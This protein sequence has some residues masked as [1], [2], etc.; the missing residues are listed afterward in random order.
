MAE[1]IFG[2]LACL[3]FVLFFWQWLCGVRFPLHQRLPGTDRLEP[4]TILKPLKGAD[5]ETLEC[6]RSWL[7]QDYSS[8]VQFLFGVA[9]LDDPVCDLVR[10]LLK[11]AADAELVIC[12]ESLGPNAKVSTLVQLEPRIKHGVVLVSDADVWAPS[13]LLQQ[14]SVGLRNAGLA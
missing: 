14:I 5:G 11:E 13:D 9:S 1:I 2:A 10:G 6:L 7:R 8:P 3:S 4:I 12:P